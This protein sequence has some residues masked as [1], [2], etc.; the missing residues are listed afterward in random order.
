MNTNRSTSKSTSTNTTNKSTTTSKSTQSSTNSK[1]DSSTKKD[2]T[3]SKKEEPYIVRGSIG[4]S[5]KVFNTKDEAIEYGNYEI[6]YNENG[7]WFSCGYDGYTID[8]S[9]GSQKWTIDFF[10]PDN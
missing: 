3:A 4:N 2:N 5:G 6:L 9:D 8:Y 7:K 10:D 1:T